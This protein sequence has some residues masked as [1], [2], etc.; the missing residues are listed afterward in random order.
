MRNRPILVTVLI[1][2]FLS[3][4]VSQA[5]GEKVIA[6]AGISKEIL[7]ELYSSESCP[8]PEN[9]RWLPGLKRSDAISL[10]KP[11]ELSYEKK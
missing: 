8:L 5:Q 9:M 2:S 4:S 3:Y 11:Q 1:G 7:V 10:Y 6:A